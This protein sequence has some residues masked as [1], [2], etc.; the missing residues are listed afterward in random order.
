MATT[1]QCFKASLTRKKEKCSA[2]GANGFCMLCKTVMW[3]FKLCKN[4][5]HE[6]VAAIDPQS[7]QTIGFLLLFFT[8]WNLILKSFKGNVLPVPSNLSESAFRMR[9]RIKAGNEWGSRYRPYG[10]STHIRD[11]RSFIVDMG[12]APIAV[13]SRQRCSA[14]NFSKAILTFETVYKKK[15][16]E[17]AIF[18]RN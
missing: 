4:V 15:F 10:M 17:Y 18:I 16:N 9:I 7:L 3:L 8:I 1:R 6:V 13:K 11:R 14:L 2:L 5:P 12:A